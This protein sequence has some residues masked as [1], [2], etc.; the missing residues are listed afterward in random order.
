MDE[1]LST[2]EQ[3]AESEDGL[4]GGLL[5][6]VGTAMKQGRAIR[7]WR[8]ED[9]S[10]IATRM[11]CRTLSRAAVAGIESGRRRIDLDELYYVC[12]ALDLSLADM[13]EQSRL[14]A[15]AIGG[16]VVG[17]EEV[18]YQLTWPRKTRQQDPAIDELATIDD[19]IVEIATRV[20]DE[21]IR[22]LSAAFLQLNS[23]A[24]P[25][26]PDPGNIEIRS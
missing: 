13:L 19:R 7:N 9:L 23:S 21:R 25:L 10:E 12:R 1:Q 2:E 5:Y 4:Q 8:Q 16:R 15:I 14:D 26:R 20:V 18:V 11:G 3:R 6:V 24:E 22:K 17:T